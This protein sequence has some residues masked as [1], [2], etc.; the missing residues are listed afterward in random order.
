M[1][2][3][4]PSEIRNP[5][6]AIPLTCQSCD[7]PAG[8]RALGIPFDSPK[9]HGYC[10]DMSRLPVP[11]LVC[12]LAAA[13]VLVT[14][15]ALA[16]DAP[17]AFDVAN[18]D[19][20]TKPSVNFFRYANGAW[21][22]KNPIPPEFTRWGSFTELQERNLA[23]LKEIAEAASK[24][25]D[26][27]KGSAPQKI[28]DFYASGMD[29][30]QIEQEGTSPLNDEL[31]RI[32]AIK[33][34]PELAAALGRLRALG[35]EVGFDFSANQDAK[36][37]TKVIAQ[38]EQG[39]LGLPDRD[40]YVKDDADSQKVR[41][42]YLAHL[43]KMFALL[44]DTPEAAA[45]NAKVVMALETDL[46][47]ASMTRVERRDPQA[48]YH[49]LT[50]DET[51]ALLPDFAINK[52]LQ[53]V[54]CPNPGP[55]NVAQPEYL[56]ALA[57]LVKTVPLDDWKTYL[58]WHLLHYSAPLLSSAF[59]NE[60][61]EF[62]G[63][64]L[65]GAKELKPR[66][67]RVIGVINAGIN[68]GAFASGGLG[69]LLGQLYVEKTFPPEAKKRALELVD[70]LRAA[71]K[72]RINHL[73]WMT[74]ETKV[75]AQKKLAAF[76]VKIGY[77]DKWRDY[78]A[79]DI[80]RKSYVQN[81]MAAEAFEF[82]RTL[83]KIGKPVDRT[84]WGMTPPTVNAYYSAAMNEIVFPA[85]IL[86]PPFFSFTA[87][88]AINYGGI[89]MVIG[90]EMTHGFDDSGRQFDAEGNLRDWWTKED[91]EKFK[92]RAKVIID[93]FSNYIVIDDM[94][95]NGELTQ[96]ENIA[97]LGGLKIAYDAFLK[98]LAA[99]PGAAD[100]KID[101]FTPLQRFYLGYAQ[102]WRSNTRP[103]ATKLRLKTDSH[104]PPELR[105]NA[106]LSNLP[107]FM[108]AFSCP[109]DSPMV[110]PANQQVKIW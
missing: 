9:A 50:L 13:S 3:L 64:A 45:A 82:Q 48:T 12:A 47:K 95:V 49:K 101:G 108:A 76:A 72:E 59:V 20:K 109:P 97:D 17:P 37:S 79:L 105:V 68:G 27:P 54:N 1:A 78:S 18:M 104:A 8:R 80:S 84:E 25:G 77:P 2:S 61:F 19:L 63:K 81:A 66:W 56:K 39:G 4:H 51:Q 40:Y 22:D 42:G 94:H 52:F 106:P 57:R 15:A 10:I 24:K 92:E 60:D 98:A 53:A 5:K 70:N 65:T 32:A 44:G 21:I 26:A 36:D 91:G 100:K 86:Q 71:L 74:P 67:K 99:N 43:T 83:G 110:R 23:T 88:D 103:E 87:D 93:Q 35:V 75:Q 46:A 107:E 16:A 7:W 102:V 11:P 85:G 73:E 38:I 6:S 33:D 89:G 96:G 31:A 58:R 41:D 62:Y 28:G 90:H 34:R 14:A 30:A 29:E 55:I 69:E